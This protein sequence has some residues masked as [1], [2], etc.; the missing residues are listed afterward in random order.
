MTSSS[1]AIKS[2]GR[3]IATVVTASPECLTDL[4][5]SDPISGPKMS[6]AAM[7]RRLIGQLDSKLLSMIYKNPLNLPRKERLRVLAIG[8]LRMF[9]CYS[10]EAELAIVMSYIHVVQ[11]PR[12]L[13]K[14]SRSPIWLCHMKFIAVMTVVHDR[15]TVL[16]D[17][18]QRKNVC[19]GVWLGRYCTVA[20]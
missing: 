7:S 16:P 13:S 5:L 8:V 15:M 12:R 20:C 3:L 18:A 14:N 9:I 19:N 10:S 6:S 11:A 2:A 4:P 17:S 1:H